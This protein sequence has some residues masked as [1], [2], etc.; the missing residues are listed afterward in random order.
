MKLRKNEG[1]ESVGKNHVHFK[2]EGSESVGKIT[3]TLYKAQEMKTPRVWEKNHVH[4][5]TKLKNVKALRVWENSHVLH[6]KTK[7]TWILVAE[8]PPPKKKKERR[9]KSGKFT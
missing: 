9:K 5:S 6:T 7:A 2:N 3:F 4:F 8:I 1:S